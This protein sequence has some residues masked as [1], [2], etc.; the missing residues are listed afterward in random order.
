MAFTWDLDTTWALE[1]L[2]VS[3]RRVEKASNLGVSVRTVPGAE[4]AGGD[5]GARFGLGRPL[6]R[7]APGQYLTVQGYLISLIVQVPSTI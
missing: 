7:D 3:T 6:R 4:P 1:T 5:L 2:T